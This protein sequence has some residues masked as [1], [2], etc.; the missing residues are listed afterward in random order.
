MTKACESG[1]AGESKACDWTK[2]WTEHKANI[3]HQMFIYIYKTL[4]CN[5]QHSIINSKTG[6]VTLTP[7]SEQKM[8]M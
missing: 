5:V 2:P 8:L 7:N 1:R 3:S 6:Q 4:K